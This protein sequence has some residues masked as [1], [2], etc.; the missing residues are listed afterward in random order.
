MQRLHGFV[1]VRMSLKHRLPADTCKAGDF[2]IVHSRMEGACCS[3]WQHHET[4][5]QT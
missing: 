2:A 4:V 1:E 3:R 5:A